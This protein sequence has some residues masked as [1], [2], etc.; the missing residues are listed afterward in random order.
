MENQK[1]VDLRNKWGYIDNF[2]FILQAHLQQADMLLIGGPGSGKSLFISELV[3][4]ES[5]E[6]IAVKVNI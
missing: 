5:E 2:E 3:K 1:I 6:V 4:I